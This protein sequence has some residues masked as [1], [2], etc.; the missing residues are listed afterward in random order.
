VTSDEL[1]HSREILE[2]LTTEDLRHVIHCRLA[3]E[4]LNGPTL[5]EELAQLAAQADPGTQDAWDALE[6]V[7][8]GRARGIA[9]DT[10]VPGISQDTLTEIAAGMLE[11]G[12][13]MR[14]GTA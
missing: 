9:R 4:Q 13:S 8:D 11:C 5:V 2:A 10:R 1:Q 7:D 3:R 12:P 14:F 6:L